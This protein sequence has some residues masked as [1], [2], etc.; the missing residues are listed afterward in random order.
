MSGG[1]VPV[2]DAIAELIRDHP[3]TAGQLIADLLAAGHVEAF[4]RPDG[5]LAFRITP[6]GRAEREGRS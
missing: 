4:R 6:E 1:L 5:A 2:A 3:D